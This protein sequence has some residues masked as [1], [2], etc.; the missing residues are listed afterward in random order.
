ALQDYLG[1]DVVDG[2]LAK[3]VKEHAY[4]GP[5]HRLASDLVQAFRDA[6]PEKYRPIVSD[7]FE[8]IVLYQN[9]ALSASAKKRSDGKW[10]VRVKV[11]CKKVEVDANGV[12]QERPLDEWIDL[13]VLDA[14]GTPLALERTHVDKPELERTFVV[15]AEPARAGI[16][17]LVKLID[18]K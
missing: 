3:F 4:E 11:G 18:R 2:V 5:P 6:A 8:K 15:A 1:E 16:D 12:E 17:P 9:H 7:L 10:D 13:G 14:K